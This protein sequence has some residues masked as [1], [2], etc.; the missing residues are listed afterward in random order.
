MTNAFQVFSIGWVIEFGLQTI[1]LFFVAPAP[2]NLHEPHDV[3]PIGLPELLG[4]IYRLTSSNFRLRGE[5]SR[6]ELERVSFGH[7]GHFD[8]LLETL[9]NVLLE[10]FHDLFVDVHAAGVMIIFAQL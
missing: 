8:R 9:F 6:D 2:K 7:G 5:E 1:Q 3:S 4:C 10:A